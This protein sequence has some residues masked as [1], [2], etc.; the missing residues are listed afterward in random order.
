MA[1]GK[2]THL[3]NL[4]G[5]I[6]QIW[7]QALSQLLGMQDLMGAL[8]GNPHPVVGAYGR[9]LRR[10]SRML[11]R[12]EFEIDHAHGRRLGSSIMTFLGDGVNRSAGL[13]CGPH[14]V[15]DAYQPYV[16]VLRH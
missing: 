9:F 3:Q 11:T 8:L 1:P 4:S 5:Y 16:D 13:W 2:V 6:P 15:E 12:L 7:N 10:N 14:H